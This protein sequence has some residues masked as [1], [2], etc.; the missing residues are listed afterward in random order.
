MRKLKIYSTKPYPTHRE[1]TSR[2]ESLLNMIGAVYS[3]SL[4]IKCKT[5]QNLYAIEITCYLVIQGY[6]T[7]FML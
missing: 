7:I 4:E 6:L 5:Y 3:F 1:Y 2:L